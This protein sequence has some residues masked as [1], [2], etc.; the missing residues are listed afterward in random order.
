MKKHSTHSTAWRQFERRAAILFS[1]VRNAFSGAAPAIT[2]SRADVRHPY[3][4][5]EAKYRQSHSVVTV[6][7]DAA[8]KAAV[9]GNKVAVVVLAEKNQPG[10]WILLHSDDLTRLATAGRYDDLPI[11]ERG[12]KDV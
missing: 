6:W 11:F 9:E 2:G 7:R 3:L 10:C 4:F 5:I 8:R 12:V 1:G